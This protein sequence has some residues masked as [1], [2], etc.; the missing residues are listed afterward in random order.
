MNITNAMRTLAILALIS[1]PTIS[2]AQSDRTASPTGSSLPNAVEGLIPQGLRSPEDAQRDLF[3]RV[4]GISA[5]KVL[6]DIQYNGTALKNALAGLVSRADGIS[7]FLDIERETSSLNDEIYKTQNFINKLTPM[8]DTNLS[9]FVDEV[10]DDFPN[11]VIIPNV[12]R[13]PPDLRNQPLNAN[14]RAVAIP[15]RRVGQRQ[16]L[17]EQI[18]DPLPNIIIISNPLQAKQAEANSLIAS[19]NK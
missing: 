4:D 3:K 15:S 14:S 17:P 18:F 8:T 1:A 7:V 6:Y 16:F 13:L 9:D 19:L 12:L 11:V 2:S 10:D 5:F